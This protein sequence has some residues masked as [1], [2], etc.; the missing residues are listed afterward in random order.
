MSYVNGNEN[1]EL[2]GTIVSMSKRYEDMLKGLMMNL[3]NILHCNTILV[4]VK[5]TNH[6]KYWA[7]KINLMLV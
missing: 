6:M 3:L 7:L 5:S 1:Y 4:I 2:C